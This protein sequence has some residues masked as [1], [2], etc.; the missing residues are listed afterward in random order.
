MECPPGK[1]GVD[2]FLSWVYTQEAKIN[3]YP[4]SLALEIKSECWNR[5][6][7]TCTLHSSYKNVFSFSSCMYSHRKSGIYIQVKKKKAS[8]FFSPETT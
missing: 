3:V 8:A 1:H 5:K 4:T 6:Q 7:N 2:K